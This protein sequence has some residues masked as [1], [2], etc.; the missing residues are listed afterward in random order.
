MNVIYSAVANNYDQ[1]PLQVETISEQVRTELRVAN[2]I[3]K[4]EATLWNRENKW[5]NPPVSGLWSLYLDGSF[6]IKPEAKPKIQGVVEGWLD[7]H[8]MAA[9]RHPWR[10]CAYDEI[11]ECVKLGRITAEE[12]QRARGHLMLA[13]FPRN[14]GLW[15]LGIMARRVHCNALQMFVVPGVWNMVQELAR[16]QIW[17][18]YMLWKIK[19]SKRRLHTIEG[20]IYN[21]KWFKFTRHKR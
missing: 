21:S 17:F 15:S 6:Q 4:K 2:F 7:K 12:G 14:Y 8:D 13:G 16:D 3:T 20:D 11:D 5:I 19:D 10:D 1:K 9:F 18:P